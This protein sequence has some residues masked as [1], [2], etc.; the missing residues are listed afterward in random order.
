MK[1]LQWKLL[2]PVI[3]M[4]ILSISALIVYKDRLEAGIE[5]PASFNNMLLIII[6][7]D[8][9]ILFLISIL[10]R[11]FITSPLKKLNPDSVRG[12]NGNFLQK[13]SY[14][15]KEKMVELG[16]TFQNLVKNLRNMIVHTLSA[17]DLGL[18]IAEKLD[19]NAGK[20]AET[21]GDVSNTAH[22]IKKMTTQLAEIIEEN[23]V[24]MSQMSGSIEK[25]THTI[26]AESKAVYTSS[27]SMEQMTSDLNEIAIT[28]HE[29]K[30]SVEKMSDKMGLVQ[31]SV[32]NVVESMA[33][34]RDKSG[35]MLEIVE[36][37]GKISDKTNLLAMNAAIEAAHAGAYGSGFKV[38]AT[39][40]KKL[41]EQSNSNAK[42]IASHINDNL[43]RI[44]EAAER[45]GS[46]LTE[47]IE[48]VHDI[49]DTAGAMVSIINMVEKLSASHSQVVDTFRMLIKVTDE[50]KV[51]S[52]EMNESRLK[53]VEHLSELIGIETTTDAAASYILKRIEE[54]LEA[55]D[56]ISSLM[57]LNK[58]AIDDVQ[59]SLSKFKVKD[60]KIV[61]VGSEHTSF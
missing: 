18:S 23:A 48:L 44:D 39:E 37:I 12:S 58:E 13:L 2:V 16:D 33:D 53:V 38:V 61:L 5:G 35:A 3:G 28:A 14:L 29:K 11:Y 56:D 59:I 7:C 27:E 10:I 6:L 45:G 21:I 49:G 4:F 51:A 30:Q 15:P 54:V 43:T 47:F 55:Q 52:K 17:T 31:N 22:S 34:I 57:V 24:L 1:S 46:I 26:T 9:V 40:I 36:I 60:G 8:L 32:T 41:A 25:L 20:S 19:K 42:Q 50:V